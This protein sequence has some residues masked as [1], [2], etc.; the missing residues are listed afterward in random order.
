MLVYQR[1]NTMFFPF[2]RWR[3]R[4]QDVDAAGRWKPLGDRVMDGPKLSLGATHLEMNPKNL[5]KGKISS[6]LLEV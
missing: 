2:P 3:I 5:P 1:V 6:C 4:S